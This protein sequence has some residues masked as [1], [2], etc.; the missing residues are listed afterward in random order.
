MLDPQTN[1]H[2]NYVD[3]GQKHK[4][5]S[6]P[7]T[8]AGSISDDYSAGENHRAHSENI[9]TDEKSNEV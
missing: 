9:N 8:Q 4:Y 3:S 5:K 1:I 6:K 2:N 7:L